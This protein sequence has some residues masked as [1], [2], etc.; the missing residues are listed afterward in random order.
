MRRDDFAARSVCSKK[1][2]NSPQIA[3]NFSATSAQFVEVLDFISI[4]Q[5]ARRTG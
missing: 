4:K 1:R 5:L 3:V 2:C